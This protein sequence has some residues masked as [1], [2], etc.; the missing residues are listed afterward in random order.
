MERKRFRLCLASFVVDPSLR[1]R[2]AHLVRSRTSL[3]AESVSEKLESAGP[4]GYDRL[5]WKRG[6]EFLGS[7]LMKHDPARRL[8]KS[9]GQPFHGR[10]AFEIGEAISTTRSAALGFSNRA[11]DLR[12]PP[13]EEPFPKAWLAYLRDNVFVY[14]LLSDAEQARLRREVRRFIAAKFWEGCAGLRIT[15]EMQ[16]TIAAQACLLLLGLDGCWFAEPKSILVY[17]GGYPPLFPAMMR[18]R[19]PRFLVSRDAQRSASAKER[20]GRFRRSLSPKD[21]GEGRFGGEA[22][23]T[24]RREGRRFRRCRRRASRRAD[25]PDRRRCRRAIRPCCSPAG[26]AD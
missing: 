6:R 24:G 18:G 1:R 26:G 21:G 13:S 2:P 14:R 4:I 17:P 19:P 3:A 20:G 10:S 9:P 8:S 5:R 23:I 22:N 15:E 25:R 12:K 11:A 7:I 16:V